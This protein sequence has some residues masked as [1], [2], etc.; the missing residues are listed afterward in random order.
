MSVSPADE[1]GA[2]A[3]AQAAAAP[4]PCLRSNNSIHEFENEGSN[5]GQK[6]DGL[7]VSKGAYKTEH[8][9]KENIRLAAEAFGLESLGFFTLTFAKPMFSA[10]CAQQRMNSLLTNVIRPRYGKRYIGVME[11]HESGAIHF[12]FIIHVGTDIRTGFDWNLVEAAYAE[13]RKKNFPKARQLWSAAAASAVNG[14]F[15]RKEWAFWRD[16]KRRYRW[17]GRCQML[18]IRST[19]EAIAKYTGGYIA[20]HMQNRRKEDK[21]VRLVRY[22]KEMRWVNS[23]IAFVSPKA[24]LFRRKLAAF[25]AQPHIQAAGVREYADMK[26]VFGKRWGYHLLIPIL[27]M[28]LDYY[29]TSEEAWADG[30]NVPPDSVDIRITHGQ[31]SD[32]EAQRYDALQRRKQ[33]ARSLLAP[34][35]T[36]EADGAPDFWRGGWW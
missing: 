36:K 9:L 22:G 17:L 15:L 2:L 28:Q 32:A 19:G 26:R 13:G 31:W 3:A 35:E 21:G 12:H 33:V 34:Q 23:R 16:A 8:C 6:G 25:V 4:L 27:A 11:R 30:I 18:P 7:R 1:R 24:R 29:A 5:V 10:K 20:K 14:D